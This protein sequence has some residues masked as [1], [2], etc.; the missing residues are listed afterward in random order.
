MTSTETS[1][2]TT[3]TAAETRSLSPFITPDKKFNKKRY[4]NLLR[5]M[6]IFN[7][8]EY[9]Q[10]LNFIVKNNPQQM[11]FEGDAKFQIYKI[12][13]LKIFLYIVVIILIYY[14]WF[15]I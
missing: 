11:K 12:L 3:P 10:N 6:D 13:C 2:T 14:L 7:L 5:R 4:N 1:R 9:L 15:K 8:F